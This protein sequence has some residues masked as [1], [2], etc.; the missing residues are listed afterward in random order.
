LS[1]H[2]QLPGHFPLSVQDE[3]DWA[4]YKVLRPARKILPRAD[5]KFVMGNH[6]IR[7]VSYLADKGPKLGSLRNM[8]FADLFQLDKLKIG[9]VCRATFLNPS[10]R[11]RQVDIA[12]NWET[13]TTPGGRPLW[14]TVHGFLTG[15][16]AA[17]KHV[18]RFMSHGTNGH[19]HDRQMISV[20]SHS[21]GVLHWHQTPCM[22]HP[23]AVA[24]GYIQGPV[25]ATGWSCGFL[26]V[27]IHP[28]SGH[29]HAEWAVV[30]DEIATF[31]GTVWKINQTE[32]DQ[33]QEM[34]EI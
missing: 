4:V 5:I 25:E 10:A 15:K 13:I 24:A 7:L 16:D 28:S 23:A 26:V 22:A 14:T 17:R 31:R 8:S 33:I 18:G 19:M 1:T 20:G 32:R 9:L 21:T 3:I 11:H 34:M 30:G 2:R 12:Q 27:T 29:V 6:D